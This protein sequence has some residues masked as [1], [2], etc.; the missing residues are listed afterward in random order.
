MAGAVLATG[1]PDSE[2]PSNPAVQRLAGV[3]ADKQ[4]EMYR[5]PD[6]DPLRAPC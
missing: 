1:S 5:I 6:I 3:A 4:E 2:M